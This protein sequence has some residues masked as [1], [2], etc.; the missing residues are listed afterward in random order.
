M[1]ALMSSTWSCAVSGYTAKSKEEFSQALARCLVLDR[2][3]I[4]QRAAQRFSADRMALDYARVYE[5]VA[6]LKHQ[7]AGMPAPL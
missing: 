3:Q 4:R 1:T 5:S 6:H 7:A 2:R